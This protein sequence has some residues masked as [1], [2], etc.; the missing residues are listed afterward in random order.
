MI[1]TEILACNVKFVENQI[2]N[3]NLIPMKKI[4]RTFFTLAT[5]L[6]FTHSQAQTTLDLITASPDHTTLE[7]LVNLSPATSGLYNAP[8][9]ITVFAPNDAAFDAIPQELLDY[10][11]AD[12]STFLQ[13]ILYYHVVSGE[14][15]TANLTDGATFNTILAGQSVTIS[16]DGE[17]IMVNNS[18][19]EVLN[20]NASNGR[21]HGLDGVLVPDVEDVFDFIANSPDHTTLAAAIVAAELQDDLEALAPYTVFAPTDAAFDALPEN[22]V[23]A[24][25]ADPTGLLQ[26]ILLYHVA[27]TIAASTDLT[28]GQ[29]VTTLNGETVLV[30]TD[31]GVFIN[32]AN[33]SGAD[34]LTLNGIVHVIDEVLI[35]SDVPTV[36]DIVVESEDHNTLEAAVIAAELDDDLSTGAALTVFA[37][38]DA[39][40]ELLPEG[41][42][43]LLLTD[44]TGILANVLL[45][46]VV[47]SI[48]LA[49]DLVD[50]ETLTTLLGQEV[51]ISNDGTTI[52]I[53]GAVV[54]VANIPA[55]NGVVHVLDAVLIPAD[56]T[57]VYDVIVNS[58]DHTTLEAAVDAAE[59]DDDLQN[60]AALTVFAPTD[61]A[62]AAL[63]ENLVN[64][65][66][67]DPTGTLAEV[68]LYHVVEG[69]APSSSLT[70]DQAITTLFG[71]DVVVDLVGGVFINGAEVTVADIPTINGV[72]HVIDAVLVPEGA[73]SILDIVV[74]S[75]VHNTLETAV[76]AAELDGTLSGPGTFT[77]FAPTDDAFAALPDGILDILLAD[78][79]GELAEILLYH[80]VGSIELAGD[81]SDGQI[82]TMENGEDVT[83]SAEGDVVF[84]NDAQV[85][86]TNL[87]GINGVVH[88]IDAVLVP[89][90]TICTDLAAGPYTDFN[91]AFGGAPVSEFGVCPTNQITAFEAWASESYTVDNFVAGQEYTFSICEGP[92]AGSWDAELT[93]FDPD[94]ALIAIA[95]DCEITWTAPVDGTYIIG[96]QEVGECGT[97]STNQ[98]TDN[99]FPTLSCTSDNTVF[100]IISNSEDH[101]TLEAAILAAELAGTLSGD[102]TFT[103]FAPTDDAFAALDPVLLEALLADPT[104]LLA[105]ILTYHVAPIAALSGDLSDGQMVTTVNGESVTITLDGGNV[106]VNGALVTL[107]DLEAD[108]GVVH[109]I[110]AVLLPTELTTVYDIVV[111]SEDHNTLETAINTAGLDVAL[112]GA[113]GDVTLFAPTD[114]AFDL[115]DEGVLDALL[116]D[117]S[118]DLTEVLLYHV[119][120][121]FN[122]AANITAGDV[123]TLF[124]EDVSI[125][126]V[127][128]DVMVD[129]AM[130]TVTDLVGINGVVHVIDAVLIPS[131]LSVEEISSVESFSVF[132]NPANNVMNVEIGMVTSERISIDFVNMLGQV[133]KSIDLGQR[134]TGLN[135]EVID[136]QDMADGFYLMNITIGKDQLTHKLQVVR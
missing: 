46:H 40:F 80:V 73:T 55:I 25:L 96:I 20:I 11:T 61:A 135:R 1:F 98:N 74:N 119:I 35:P 106:L 56:Q 6:F 2:L 108:N 133:V 58:E 102:G 12:P 60:G 36:L 29:E 89:E 84:I 71:E 136:I 43:D 79:T 99:G 15:T 93:V 14:Q 7:E 28:D 23:N 122:I 16:N 90:G 95:Q 115:L 87:V 37:P 103:V 70:Q 114:A 134:S 94:G 22:L 129:D 62:F 121:G 49:D 72:V 52:S 64:A 105:D 92:G 126:L 33:V 130:V 65:L 104:N 44:P 45:Q 48:E 53:D 123:P 112:S 50:G 100:T 41:L 107:A 117:P 38:T 19:I 76:I 21:L 91:G 63:P 86:A 128:G 17:T 88:V 39:A 83:V 4:L 68:L 13:D 69:I 120:E 34:N 124:G 27:P 132:P 9:P 109:V 81:L 75:D 118:G 85:T 8:G 31:G 26:D 101:N 3:L 10:Y 32:G 67:E 51:T 116:D 82:I 5:V 131:T 125:T 66:L 47:G 59:L 97:S 30:D 42:V 24:L 127:D 111:N 113:A 54:S 18:T 77:L 57:T 110:D 78:P